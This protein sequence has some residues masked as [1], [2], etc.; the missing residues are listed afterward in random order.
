MFRIQSGSGVYANG[1]YNF[2]KNT[3][4]DYHQSKELIQDR[5][6]DIFHSTGGIVGHRGM[7][8]FL[9]REGIIKMFIQIIEKSNSNQ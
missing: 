4:S 1:Y 8:I 3:K 6:K 5:I 7:V 9:A 2:L